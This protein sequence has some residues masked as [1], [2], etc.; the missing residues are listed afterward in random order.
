MSDW[1]NKLSG[2]FEQRGEPRPSVEGSP[3]ARFIADVVVPAFEDLA[4]ELEKHG[5]SV[6]IRNALT[7]AAIIVSCNGEE[8]MTYRV[9]GR[10]LPTDV[11]PYAEIRFRERKGRRYITVESMFRSGASPYKMSDITREEV[12]QNFL[13]NYARRVQK[14]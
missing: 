1:R 2:I 6:I 14:G 3:L 12:I 10:T 8:E 13:N 7:S 11:L 9:Q 4:P 5:R